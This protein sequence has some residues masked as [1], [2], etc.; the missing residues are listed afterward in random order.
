MAPKEAGHASLS[1]CASLSINRAA[2]DDKL[3]QGLTPIMANP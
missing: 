3:S 2:D 1:A